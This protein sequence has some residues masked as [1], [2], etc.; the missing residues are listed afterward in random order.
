M[1]IK[2]NAIAQIYA[3]KQKDNESMQDCANRLKQYITR[4]PSNEKPR[5]ARLISIFLEGLH[6]KTLHAHLYIKKHTSFNECCLDPMDYD[7]IFYISSVSSH[8]N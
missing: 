8:G 1:G 4:Y 3:F 7:D 5:H 2:H 6:N